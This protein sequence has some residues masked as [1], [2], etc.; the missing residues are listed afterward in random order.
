MAEPIFKIDLE[1]DMKK[2]IKELTDD[3]N[4]TSLE[5]DKDMQFGGDLAM[6]ALIV[7]I[8]FFLL[9]KSSTINIKLS[10]NIERLTLVLTIFTFLIFILTVFMAVLK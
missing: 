8:N 4:K 1:K 7:R 2:S 5:W 6:Q 9:T 3:I 10:K